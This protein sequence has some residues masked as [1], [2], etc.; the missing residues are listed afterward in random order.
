MM[1]DNKSAE[2][3]GANGT[4]MRSGRDGYV[5][6]I[7]PSAHPNAAAT[8]M[9]TSLKDLKRVPIGEK[10]ENDASCKHYLGGLRACLS[11]GVSTD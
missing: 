10:N 5:C 1:R 7:A 6:D 2:P 8:K 11:N 3:P 9:K 4:M